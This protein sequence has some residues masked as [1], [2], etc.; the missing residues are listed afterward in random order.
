MEEMRRRGTEL[1]LGRLVLIPVEGM[2]RREGA[3]GMRGMIIKVDETLRLGGS[4]A[5]GMMI[6]ITGAVET[7]MM[8][9]F[10][11]LE[12]MPMDTAII[13]PIRM[14]IPMATMVTATATDPI[15]D[16]PTIPDRAQWTCQTDP[17][18]V[19]PLQHPAQTPMAKV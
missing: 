6:E 11:H 19:H 3:I 13:A 15:L 5:R 4:S 9:V 18:P 8:I 1:G 7:G 16:H 2:S 12:I 17:S 14:A 10:R